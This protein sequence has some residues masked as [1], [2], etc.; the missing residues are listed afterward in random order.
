MPLL[1]WTSLPCLSLSL[2]LASQ[3]HLQTSGNLFINVAVHNSPVV[4][5]AVV[6]CGFNVVELNFVGFNSVYE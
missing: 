1:G 5:L 6:I 3:I 4:L 2:S